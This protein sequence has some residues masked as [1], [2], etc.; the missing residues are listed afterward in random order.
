MEENLCQLF[1]G[2]GLISIMYQELKKLNSRR[3]N[4]PINQWANELNSI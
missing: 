4:N 1:N 2:E 3:T